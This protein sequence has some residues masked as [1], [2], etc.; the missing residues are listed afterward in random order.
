[1][2]GDSILLLYKISVPL[3]TGAAG[4]FM[5][6]PAFTYIKLHLMGNFWITTLKSSFL[7]VKDCHFS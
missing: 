5:I 1:M 7:T 2:T 4:R 6:K 3:K